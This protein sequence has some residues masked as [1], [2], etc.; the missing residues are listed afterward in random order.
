MKLSDLFEQ[1][2]VGVVAKN[3]KQAKDPRYSMSMTKDVQPGETE[4]QAAKFGNKLD[5]DGNPPLLRE[6][7]EKITEKALSSVDFKGADYKLVRAQTL[8]DKIENGEELMTVDNKMV[9]IAPSKE[10]IDQIRAGN[11][12]SQ[13]PLE[14]GGT[15]RLSQLEK[16]SD[17]GGKGAGSGT[18]VEEGE[19]ANLS[20]QIEELRGD[21][22]YIMLKVANDV[23]EAAGVR[24]TPGTPKSDFE[25]VDSK[26]NPVAFI[27]HKDGSPADPKK[28]G[29]WAG[30]TSFTEHPEVQKFI[31]LVKKKY[32]EG[33][34]KGETAI[35]RVVSDTDLQ[36]RAM[37]GKDW[38]KG[39]FGIN[40]VTLIMQ[41]PVKIVETKDGYELRSLA[42]F[43]NGEDV[44]DAYVPIFI[45]RYSSDRND[46]KL[47]HTRMSLYPAF[48]RKVNFASDEDDAVA[49]EPVKQVEPVTHRVTRPDW[50][51]DWT[52][53]DEKPK[54]T[55]RAKRK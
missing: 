47:P 28:F 16:T 10:L 31:E 26:G 38:N 32:P 7:E 48:G 30:L 53:K 36:K 18:H 27:S 35:A 2:G 50:H 43:Y 22:P 41:G 24:K 11:I 5:K 44:P 25:I 29:Q 14:I 13:L 4:R 34:K 46:F 55:G 54:S 6:S 49:V 8:A 1:G 17:F 3:A 42:E 15:I 45:A 19:I 23:V 52:G 40:N 12:P 39:D 20:K 9:K 21:E 37:Y 33:M 51:K